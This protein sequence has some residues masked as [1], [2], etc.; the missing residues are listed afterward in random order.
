MH[1]GPILLP[2]VVNDLPEN[3]EKGA[4]FTDLFL[5][6]PGARVSNRHNFALFI[7][8]SFKQYIA[9]CYHPHWRY[10]ITNL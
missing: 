5:V 1:K 10:W 9:I 6:Q 7:P 4:T 3:L 8:R 2:R